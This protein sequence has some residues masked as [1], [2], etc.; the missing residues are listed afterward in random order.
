MR[1][2]KLFL[3]FASIT[4][5]SFGQSQSIEIGKI[6][7]LRSERLNENR[8]I[9][10]FVPEPSYGN[11]EKYQVI[12]LLDGEW[13]F[14][15]VAS[16]VDKLSSS[17]EIPR[18]IVVGIF[19]TNRS[20]DLTPAGKGDDTERH[21]GAK[22]FLDFLCDELQPW[23]QS[24]YEV[25]PYAIL[26]GHSF[27][28]LFTIYSLMEKPGA[29]QSYLALSPSLGRNDE[30]Q[31][32]VAEEFFASDAEMLESLYLAVGG[33]GGITYRST[34]KFAQILENQSKMQFRF[35]YDHLE[36]E[37]HGSITAQG[38]LSG[39]RFI[40]S[41]YNPERTGSSE[42]IFLVQ[43]HYEKLSDQFG[44]PIEIPEEYFQELVQEQI[45][46][47]ELDYALFILEKYAKSYPE[48]PNLPL[49]YADIYLLQGHFEEAR[50]S[51][52]RAKEKGIEDDRIEQILSRLED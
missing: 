10:V 29:F 30:Q 17:G 13:H 32:H 19:N 22:P 39:L 37:S 52:Q 50:E 1:Q 40:F 46:E 28:G 6:Y 33:E 45:G 26:A 9:A 7:E 4:I 16:L 20:R 49:L 14:N 34:A 36:D 5:F 8:R 15:F 3:F 25:H 24:Q 2:I 43:E 21:G 35:Q 12:Y 51:Y 27:G 23:V 48:S 47:R 41:N 42:D 38:F 11:K 44:Y 18:M 31:L